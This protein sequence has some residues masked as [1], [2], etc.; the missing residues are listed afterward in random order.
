MKYINILT[1]S[2]G[3][4]EDWYYEDENGDTLNAVDEGEVEEIDEQQN[5]VDLQNK[6]EI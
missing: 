1:G 6:T 3:E 4:Y 5:I 2:I